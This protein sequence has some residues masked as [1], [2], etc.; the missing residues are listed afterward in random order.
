MSSTIKKN[1]SIYAHALHSR[2]Q[3]IRNKLDFNAQMHPSDVVIRNQKYF[4][5]AGISVEQHHEFHCGRSEFH[6]AAEML[7]LT[8]KE[9]EADPRDLP[10]WGTGAAK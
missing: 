1:Y 3:M 6:Q 4:D 7:L 10:L 8:L 5:K 2:L 9:A